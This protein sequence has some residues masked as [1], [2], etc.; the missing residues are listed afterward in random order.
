MKNR[1]IK[2]RGYDP[3]G[4]YDE[5]S[6]KTIGAW[7]SP[8]DLYNHEY[9]GMVMFPTYGDRYTWQQYTGFKDKNDKEIYEGDYV[10]WLVQPLWM[11]YKEEFEQWGK[12]G[13][14]QQI[15]TTL[16]DWRGKCFHSDSFGPSNPALCEVIGNNIDNPEL[17][18]I[19]QH[20]RFTNGTIS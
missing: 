7:I 17:K 9:I 20:R 13:K 15:I 6:K 4:G 5:K 10:Q 16:V 1:E 3:Y 2:F 19:E 11:R 18:N 12:E 8:L 14:Y